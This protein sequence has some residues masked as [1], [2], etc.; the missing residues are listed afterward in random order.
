MRSLVS[1]EDTKHWTQHQPSDRLIKTCGRLVRHS[2]GW[3]FILPRCWLPEK[4][5]S[6]DRNWS[7]GFACPWLTCF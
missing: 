3:R 7:A 2:R 5:W 4:C 6:G 1:Q